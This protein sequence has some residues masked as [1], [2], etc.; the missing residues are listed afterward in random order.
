MAFNLNFDLKV[1]NF[2][3]FPSLFS[4][5]K[6]YYF[7]C[8]TDNRPSECAKVGS[9]RVFCLFA[10][11]AVSEWETV[12][13]YACVPSQIDTFFHCGTQKSEE[14]EKKSYNSM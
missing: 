5:P 1:L 7:F 12:V 13:L 2:Y 8:G 3:F 10:L 4:M 9:K 6:V 14:N 11:H